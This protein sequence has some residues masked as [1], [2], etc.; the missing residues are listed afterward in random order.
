MKKT[1]G[2]A[3]L[4]ATLSFSPAHAILINFDDPSICCVTVPS[5]YQGFNW[6]DNW[7]VSPGS[8]TFFTGTLTVSSAEFRVELSEHHV[9]GPFALTQLSV[10]FRQLLRT[11]TKW[12]PVVTHRHC[13]RVQ[14]RLT[15]LYTGTL[16][17]DG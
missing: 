3:L 6:S 8:V 4:V 11:K 16:D 14:R 9:I 15:E 13:A 12:N 17:S 10:R 2:A 7:A 5:N 1:I